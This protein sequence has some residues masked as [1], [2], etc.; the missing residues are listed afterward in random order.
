MISKITFQF[1]ISVCGRYESLTSHIQTPTQAAAPSTPR[2][3]STQWPEATQV[4]TG[5]HTHGLLLARSACSRDRRVHAPRAGEWGTADPL[6]E[7]KRQEAEQKEMEHCHESEEVWVVG[8]GLGLE[9]TEKRS[10]HG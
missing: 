4:S 1:R 7:C 6:S 2:L 10:L 3:S 8:Q 5:L 9:G